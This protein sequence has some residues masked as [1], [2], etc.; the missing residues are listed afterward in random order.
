MEGYLVV[1]VSKKGDICLH[2]T[3]DAALKW[4]TDAPANF[5]NVKY[6]HCRKMTKEGQAISEG[7]HTR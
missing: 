2:C 1:K 5:S 6:L 7:K 4:T 3:L